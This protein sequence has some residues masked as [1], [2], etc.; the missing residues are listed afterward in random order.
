MKETGAVEPFSKFNTNTTA[1]M[2]RDIAGKIASALEGEI[3]ICQEEGT[4]ALV[5]KEPY[6]VVLGIAPW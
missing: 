4:G 6:G 2:F 5:L 1:E 3:P